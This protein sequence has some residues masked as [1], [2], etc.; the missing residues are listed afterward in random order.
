MKLMRNYR[1]FNHVIITLY[2]SPALFQD[3]KYLTAHRN[4]AQNSVDLFFPAAEIQNNTNQQIN[5]S[6]NQSI[7]YSD[8]YKTWTAALDNVNM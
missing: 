5:Q 3:S 4:H 7:F 1:A 6:I 8:P 2:N